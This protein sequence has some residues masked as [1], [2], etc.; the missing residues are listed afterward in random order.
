M[1]DIKELRTE[2]DKIDGEMIA[3]FEKRMDVA[4]KIAEYKRENG[5]PVLDEEREALK[6]RE[7]MDGARPEYKNYL[8]AL[9]ISIFDM[10][11]RYQETINEAE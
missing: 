8:A 3:L 2:I 4:A 10:S 9:Y 6:L 7:I 11:R 1:Q 5:L